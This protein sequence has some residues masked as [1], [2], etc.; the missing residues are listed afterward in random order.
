[1]FIQ[2]I[3]TIKYITTCAKTWVTTGPA[4]FLNVVFQRIGNIIMYHETYVFLIDS[5]TKCRCSHNDMYLIIHKGILI[6]VF[7]HLLPSCH[8]KGVP[9]NRRGSIFQPV[10]WF[11]WFV[12]RKQLS[13]NRIL[14]QVLSALNTCHC[15]SLHV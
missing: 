9:Y 12:I 13:D 1:M 8:R 5:H 10:L 11:A 15:H 14:Q 3:V 6:G 4:C 7:F 2:V